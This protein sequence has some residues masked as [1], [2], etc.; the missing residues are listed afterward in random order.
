MGDLEQ[1]GAG[2]ARVTQVLV[3]LGRGL[4]QQLRQHEAA[5]RTSEAESVRKSFESF[6]GKL[7]ARQQQSFGT[8]QYLAESYFA[9]GNY[10]KAGDTFDRMLQLAE[11][12][13]AV[14]ESKEMRGEIVRVR[15]RRATA[16]RLTSK[17]EL[18]LEEL[19]VLLKENDRLL[20]AIMEK[21]RVLQD[22][23]EQN[24]PRLLDAAKHWDQTSKRLQ[25]S[26]P[27]P[28][29]YFEARYGLA[30]SLSRLGK[31]QDAIKVLR[32]TMALSAN[33]GGPELRTK[34]ESLL[35]ELDAT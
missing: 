34:Y 19:D 6:L 15:L 1:Q 35:R 17:F 8:L 12:D 7:A 20:P 32:S 22:W 18:A 24:P 4:E 29:E 33:V 23:G 10:E 28:A 30:L 14:G 3:G 9:M 5:G 2:T 21:G 16:L 26:S 25:T 13:P 31:K 27:R 11:Q